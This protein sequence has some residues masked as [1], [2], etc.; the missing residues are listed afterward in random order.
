MQLGEGTKK[1][2]GTEELALENIRD[3][4]FSETWKRE[5]KRY[6]YWGGK[7]KVKLVHTGG[8]NFLCQVWGKILEQKEEVK[9]G[10]EFE[11]IWRK[12]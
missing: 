7:A 6:K 2:N 9:L 4:T 8:L 1:K 11:E 3:A 12:F 5:G 10:M